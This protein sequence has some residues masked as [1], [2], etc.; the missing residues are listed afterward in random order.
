MRGQRC[1]SRASMATSSPNPRVARHSS[2]KFTQP[3]TVVPTAAARYPASGAPPTA[4]TRLT[5]IETT[6]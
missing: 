5:I 2:T 3:A 1:A 4:M 6:A